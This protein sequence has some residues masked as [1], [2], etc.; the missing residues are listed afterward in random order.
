[1]PDN[2]YL[3]IDSLPTMNKNIPKDY[4]VSSQDRREYFKKS[5]SSLPKKVPPINIILFPMEADPYAP[6]EYWE[7]ADKT[8]GS[9]IQPQKDWPRWRK[10]VR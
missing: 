5:V 9:F 7:L 4:T 10:N 2:I 1:M 6:I 8:G 3:L